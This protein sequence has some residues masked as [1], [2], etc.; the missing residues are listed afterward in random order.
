MGIFTK[1]NTKK[2]LDKLK[3]PSQSLFYDD[4]FEV[5]VEKC[6][7]EYIKEYKT[8]FDLSDIA[9]ILKRMTRVIIDHTTYSEGYSYRDIISIDLVFIFLEIVNHTKGSPIILHHY[10]DVSDVIVPI[11]IGT[12]TFEY[13]KYSDGIMKRYNKVDKCFNLNGY[14]ISLPSTGI[15]EDLTGFLSSISAI[16]GSEKF[17]GYDY[18]FLYVMGTET[19]LSVKK[20][21]DIINI[22][23]I[24]ITNEEKKNLKNAVNKVKSIQK[25]TI[26]HN[27]ES[28]PLSSKLDL[29]NIFD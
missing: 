28:I 27:G 4:G 23:N 22:F 12:H 5:Y 2:K 20:M 14:M 10:D 13:H 15:E 3:L 24:D 16:P 29:L 6:K 1:K 21:V 11:E 18:N 17:N 7:P 19:E 25:Y 8:N 26:R 9:P